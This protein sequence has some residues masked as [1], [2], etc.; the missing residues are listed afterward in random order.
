MP[1]QCRG[2]QRL[3]NNQMMLEKCWPFCSGLWPF[4]IHLWL[5]S[6]RSSLDISEFYFLVKELQAMQY[7]GQNL[8]KH[9]KILSSRHSPSQTLSLWGLFQPFLDFP[10]GSWPLWRCPSEGPLVL[11]LWHLLVFTRKSHSESKSQ[12]RASPWL[13]WC[14]TGALV[15][16]RKGFS[17]HKTPIPST[18][19]A[20]STLISYFHI[21]SAG[22]G[23]RLFWDWELELSTPRCG[24][25]TQQSLTLTHNHRVPL[26]LPR[27]N[28]KSEKLRQK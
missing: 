2:C 16:L 12:G 3:G 4:E 21:P 15:L 20:W 8:I 23:A 28:C 7:V 22:R 18:S 11:Q 10:D 17:F 5:N 27:S 26:T 9:L 25:G 19:M 14:H 24:T 1:Q 13:G 6:Q